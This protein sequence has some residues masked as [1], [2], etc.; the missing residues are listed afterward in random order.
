MDRVSMC[1]YPIENRPVAHVNIIIYKVAQ[2]TR[3]IFITES[4]I[5]HF[6]F[7]IKCIELR[8][9]SRMNFSKYTPRLQNASLYY[10]LNN[11]LKNNHN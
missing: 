3:S 6:V 7:A 1:L 10:V 8:G 11:S 5:G 4:L 9:H 2:K